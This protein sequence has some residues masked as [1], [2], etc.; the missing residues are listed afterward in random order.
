[1]QTNRQQEILKELNNNRSKLSALFSLYNNSLILAEENRTEL[2]NYFEQLLDY[3]NELSTITNTISTFKKAERNTEF[4]K[5]QPKI[6]KI[7]KDLKLINDEFNSAT[8]RF[9]LALQECGSLKT[10]YKHDVSLL[11]KE[12]KTTI[13]DS[14]SPIILKGYKQQVKII[15]TILDRIELLIS[16]Y[17]VKKNKVE[18]DSERFNELYNNATQLVSR[19]KT[20]A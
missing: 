16:D 15:R 12:F 11:C 20:S 19:L 7:G 18:Q 9:K 5:I 1:M 14:T 4:A 13:D 3:R 10:E 6:K 2:M 8:E 17:N